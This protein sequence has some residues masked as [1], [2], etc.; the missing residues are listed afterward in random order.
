MF[1]YFLFFAFN[2]R[3]YLFGGYTDV[4]NEESSNEVISWFSKNANKFVRHD[5]DGKENLFRDFFFSLIN[6]YIFHSSTFGL[7]CS[8]T[9]QLLSFDLSKKVWEEVE[10]NGDVPSPRS[11]YA[12]VLVQDK[13]YLFGGNGSGGEY[14]LPMDDFYVLDMTN[15]KW[16]VVHEVGGRRPPARYQHSLTY[17]D[18]MN[19]LF[20][21]GGLSDQY[22]GLGNVKVKFYSLLLLLISTFKTF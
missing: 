13:L 10:S 15:F 5:N 6:T 1:S 7:G 4:Q 9:N 18:H 22:E 19:S 16:Q 2:F 21:H 3:I 8:W 17:I 11:R 14:G 20:L 12:C